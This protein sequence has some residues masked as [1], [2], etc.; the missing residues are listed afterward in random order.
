MW[1]GQ[2]FGRAHFDQARDSAIELK[3]LMTIAGEIKAGRFRFG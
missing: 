2:I 3:R 1:Q